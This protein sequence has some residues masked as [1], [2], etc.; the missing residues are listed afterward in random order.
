M[1]KITNTNCLKFKIFSL[2]FGYFCFD[3]IYA[4]TIIPLSVGE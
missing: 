2:F 1:N 3:M 4:K